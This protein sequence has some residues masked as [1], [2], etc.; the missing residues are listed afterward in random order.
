MTHTASSPAFN[1]LSSG[2]K[3]A[4]IKAAAEELATRKGIALASALAN[5]ANEHGSPTWDHLLSRSWSKD[6]DGDIYLAAHHLSEYNFPFEVFSP[7]IELEDEDHLDEIWSVSIILCMRDNPYLYIVFG[8]ADEGSNFELDE[9]QK[10]QF[11][12]AAATGSEALAIAAQAALIEDVLTWFEI[13]WCE[14]TLATIC[15]LERLRLSIT[16]EDLLWEE[17]GFAGYGASEMH[18]RLYHAGK[19]EVMVCLESKRAPEE[20]EIPYGYISYAQY[21]AVD[22]I[23]SDYRGMMNEFLKAAEIESCT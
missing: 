1:V 5:A 21:D 12:M 10:T 23:P 15:R 17:P 13:G 2:E 4:D 7:L 16:D 6:H 18:V 11:Q 14:T 22:H 19:D 9:R 3:I 20:G 8:L